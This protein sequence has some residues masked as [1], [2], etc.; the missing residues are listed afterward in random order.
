MHS[1]GNDRNEFLA[2]RL[3]SARVSG[4]LR[5]ALAIISVGVTLGA[6]LLL[7]YLNF[8]V[9]PALLLFAVAVSS[10]YGRLGPAVLAAVLAT[11]SFFA[12]FIEPVRSISIQR[13][14]IPLF[15][16]F[17]VFSAFLAW[18]GVVRR[19]IE[20]GLRE[21]AQLLN[22]TH[23]TVFVM[24]MQGVIKYWNCG[25]AEQYGWTAE[26]ALGKV[27]HDLLKTVFPKPL[28]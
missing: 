7:Q 1:S 20:A 27:V 19:R 5:Y 26:Q 21:Q 9:P 16:I 24:D 6:G 13:S 3:E 23:D 14:D 15:I 18:F 28:A 8:R 12:F 10:W 17:V 2:D 11:I 22:L 25:A 4:V